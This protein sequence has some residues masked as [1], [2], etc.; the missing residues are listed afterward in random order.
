MGG[1]RMDDAHE[2]IGR[3]VHRLRTARGLT[4]RDLAE[5]NYTA[6]YVSSVESGRRTPSGDALR[7]FA[8]RLGVS[9]DEL[10]LGRPVDPAIELEFALVEAMATGTGLAAVAE[11]AA[12]LGDTRRQA[13]AL[14]AS[15]EAGHLDT[16]AR[17]L[18]GEPLPDRIPLILARAD[19]A[20]TEYAIHLLEEAREELS[21]AGHLDPDARYAVHSGLAAR[22]LQAGADDRA[23]EAA[24]E[25]LALAGPGDPVTVGAG[26]L[27]T[28]R[29]LLA[30]RRVTDTAV[31]LG[32]ARSA[33]RRAAL[34]PALAACFRARGRRLK[35]TG[36]LTSA[37]ADLTRARQLYGDAEEALDVS[38]DLAEV[39]RRQGHHAA[40]RALLLASLT[41]HP[42]PQT[43]PPA[44]PAGAPPLYVVRAYRELGLVALDEGDEAEAETRLR[45]AV[46]LAARRN[47]RH[48]LARAVDTLGTL[49]TT[50][51]RMSDATEALRTGLL[52]LERILHAE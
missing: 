35:T 27:A 8:A 46:T 24:D 10:A 17:L 21:A 45:D 6:G 5:P 15:G 16:A 14:L 41:D 1:D 33:Y 4:Q 20:T 47:A 51:N 30:A 44:D 49:L 50:Q 3:R 22:Y 32:Q 38:V 36:D 29:A 48:E 2:D 31:A 26:H 25:A 40:A 19:R 9:E 7:H 23:A 42:L 28:A 18:A 34:L 12:T 43:A 13:W 11:H 39:H 52:H 37:A